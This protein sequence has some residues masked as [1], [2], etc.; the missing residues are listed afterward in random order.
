MFKLEG[1]IDFHPRT[2]NFFT[3][4]EKIEIGGYSDEEVYGIQHSTL[5]SAS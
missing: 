5:M 1:D 2:Y 4:N 3:I